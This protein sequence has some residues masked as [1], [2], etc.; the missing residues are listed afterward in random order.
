MPAAA[1]RKGE[2]P[3]VYVD[4]CVFLNVIKREP[5]FWPDSLKLLLAAD[6]RDIQLVASTLVLVEVGSYKGD[7]DP[8]ER[9]AVIERYL[10]NGPVQW[11]ELDL[12]VADEARAL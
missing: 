5:T 1:K 4:S 9:N 8:V 11:Y 3:L 10:T 2:T 7:V 6:R 12:F